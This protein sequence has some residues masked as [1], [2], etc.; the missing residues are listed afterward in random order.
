MS[1][2]RL[3]VK[4]RFSYRNRDGSVRSIMRAEKRFVES[5]I[6]NNGIAIR[7]ESE[8]CEVKGRVSDVWWRSQADSDKI[9]VHTEEQVYSDGD[10]DEEKRKHV[11]LLEA[12]GWQC[13]SR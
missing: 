12:N 13:S 5:F 10:V 6:P 1:S 8:D 4:M 11:E 2:I 3:L 9:I 7:V